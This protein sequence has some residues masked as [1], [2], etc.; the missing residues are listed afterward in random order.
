MSGIG[1]YTQMVWASTHKIGCG[2]TSYKRGRF[3]KKF[4]VCNYGKAGN[5]LRAPMYQVGRPC[6]KCSSNTCSKNF[7]GLCTVS[8][9]TGFTTSNSMPAEGEGKILQSNLTN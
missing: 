9:E 4:I 6:S 8:G 5:L 2:Y 1:H 7:P 3:V